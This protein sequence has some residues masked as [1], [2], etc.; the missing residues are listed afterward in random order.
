MS[1]ENELIPGMEQGDGG[2]LTNDPIPDQN[3]GDGGSEAP[4]QPT[5]GSAAVS[6][7]ATPAFYERASR[8]IGSEF[9]NDDQVLAALVAA[10]ERIS[11]GESRQA[12]LDSLAPY[13]H[14]IQAMIEAERA[15][16]PAAPQANPLDAWKAPEL[17]EGW[18]DYYE[19]GADGKN[20]LRADTPM[21]VRA[22]INRWQ[23]WN[24][25]HN[26]R[27][28]NLPD[29]LKRLGYVTND[30]FD[31]RVEQRVNA[32]LAQ[33]RGEFEGRDLHGQMRE[34]MAQLTPKF[35]DDK[36]QPTP[37]FHAFMKKAGQLENAVDRNGN[38]RF[39]PQEIFNWAS[40]AAE[41]SIANER[42]KQVEAQAASR[43]RSGLPP[44]VS[45]PSSRTAPIQGNQP[46]LNTGGESIEATMEAMWGDI[47]K[48]LFGENSAP[49]AGAAQAVRV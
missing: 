30:D 17:P 7:P 47:S 44:A 11:A 39:S 31:Q 12:T 15:P 33:V 18:Q 3:L 43:A 8:A 41:L 26:K 9:A 40:E 34:Q 36:G 42:L 2:G 29:E 4:A 38:P 25:D 16:K 20:V 22:A 6:A 37:F 24:R 32:V 13:W 1:D 45:T 10:R 5:G 46:G 14:K 21:D 48:D 35:K 23:Q 19:A 28:Q 27:L 49:A